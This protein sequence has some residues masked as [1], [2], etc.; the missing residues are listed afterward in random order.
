MSH[1]Y[2]QARAFQLEGTANAKNSELDACLEPLK[3]S[4]EASRDGAE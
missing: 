4:K 2:I 3:S 1:V